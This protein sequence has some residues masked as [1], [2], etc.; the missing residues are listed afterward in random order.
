MKKFIYIL[1]LLVI[2]VITANIVLW[3]DYFADRNTTETNEKITEVS[4][5]S[6]ETEDQSEYESI[7]DTIEDLSA[8]KPEAAGEVANIIAEGE[9]SVNDIELVYSYFM[10]EIYWGNNYL[11]KNFDVIA[12]EWLDLDSYKIEMIDLLE[13]YSAL[14]GRL[15]GGKGRNG[16]PVFEDLRKEYVEAVEELTKLSLPYRDDITWLEIVASDEWAI[17]E[18]KTHN[19]FR[20]KEELQQNI[21]T[22]LREVST[23]QAYL[24]EE[25]I[26]RMEKENEDRDKWRR[27]Y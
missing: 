9:Y 4:S 27:Y 19:A 22:F 14:A 7:E 3:S 23:T 26:K 20:I 18:E 1:F 16:I 8:V 11:Y 21:D 15:R 6:D 2:G 25:R 10:S 12:D 13:D 17:L 24:V 5:S